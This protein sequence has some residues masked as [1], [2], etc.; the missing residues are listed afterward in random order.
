MEIENDVIAMS[1]AK[2]GVIEIKHD[3]ARQKGAHD[4]GGK[5][6]GSA[7]HPDHDD[8]EDVG[9][10]QGIPEDVS[11][12]NDCEDSHQPKGGDQIV[13]ENHHDHGNDHWHHD[14]GI[15]KGSRVG[16]SAV[17]QHI[18]PGDA[19]ATEEREEQPEKHQRHVG[20]HRA[21]IAILNPVHADLDRCGQQNLLPAGQVGPLVEGRINLA[22][23]CR[24]VEETRMGK[25]PRSDEC[26]AIDVLGGST[27]N[28][29]KDPN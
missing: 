28:E 4:R 6:H 5:L 16:E 7:C 22:M 27:L 9:R 10:V 26:G 14:Q 18:D 25:A 12:S 3:A 11:E 23:R 19:M 15:D 2:S 8:G 29:V 13:G 21:K 20:R 1:G 24:I 17:S